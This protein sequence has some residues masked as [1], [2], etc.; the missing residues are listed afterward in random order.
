[1]PSRP[2]L[3]PLALLLLAAAPCAW[4]DCPPDTTCTNGG[5]DHTSTPSHSRSGSDIFGSGSASYDLVQGSVGASAGG[6]GGDL[7]GGSGFVV[8]RDTYVLS[9]LA[10]ATPVTFHVALHVV[11]S[12]FMTCV[13]FSSSA[14]AT[15]SESGAGTV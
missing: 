11:G 10:D 12:A 7:G 5:C 6:F 15:M 9:G 8:A 2:L 4:A 13:S 1:M 14:S 3:L